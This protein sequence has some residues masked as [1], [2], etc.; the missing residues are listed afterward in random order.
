MKRLALLALSLLAAPLLAFTVVK[1]VSLPPVEKLVLFDK[2]TPPAALAFFHKGASSFARAEDGS[3]VLRI[4]NNDT[5]DAGFSWA[6]SPGLPPSFTIAAHAAI[7]VTFRLEGASRRTL[8][9]GQ[10]LS[11]RADN[12]WNVFALYDEKQKTVAVAGLA[13]GA[14]GGKTPSETVT[15]RIPSRVFTHW[16]E[17][18]RPP[19]HGFGFQWSPAA[20]SPETRDYT[21]V[22]ERVVVAD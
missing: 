16:G 2:T 13:D 14:P 17:N 20:N 7:I 3:L 19:I 6:S 9:N 1:D 8:A 4:Q 5:V 21:L 22:I 12:L 10:V 18:P 11:R 15:I